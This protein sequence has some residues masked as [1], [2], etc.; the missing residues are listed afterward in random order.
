MTFAESIQDNDPMHAKMSKP[1]KPFIDKANIIRN[2][3]IALHP[4]LR[5]KLFEFENLHFDASDALAE[6]HDIAADEHYKNKG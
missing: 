3:I 2:D 4:E 6:Q 5:S 1:C